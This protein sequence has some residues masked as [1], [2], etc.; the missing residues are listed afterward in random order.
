MNNRHLYMQK[1]AGLI[2][3]TEYNRL[4]AENQTADKL[5]QMFKDE[6]L[7][8]DRRQYD[9]EDLISS[10]PGLS[11][12]EAEKLHQKLQTISE[13]SLRSKIK[14]LVQ[15][16]LGEAKKKKAEDETDVA[17]QEDEPTDTIEPTDADMGM[18]V[19]SDTEVDTGL[20]IDPKV[21][22]IQNLLQ[23]A[24][25]NAKSLGDEKLMTQI[26]NTITMVVRNQVLGGQGNVAESLNEEATTDSQKIGIIQTIVDNF[27]D[28]GINP[29]PALR[30]IEDV[31]QNKH[32]EED[33]ENA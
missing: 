16:S 32:D 7:L 11:K 30:R 17:P 6:G 22:N 15:S 24:Y 28:G 31:L 3:E 8:N 18:D 10:Y 2:T 19:P 29:E 4:I 12:E 33:L 27:F 13:S 20:D 25:A 5:Y 1:L 26:G 23:K 21:K 9:V 14:E